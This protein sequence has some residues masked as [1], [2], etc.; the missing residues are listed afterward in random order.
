MITEVI[1]KEI[2]DAH[3]YGIS[4][5]GTHKLYT[6]VVREIDS[7]NSDSSHQTVSAIQIAAH[8]S[9]LEQCF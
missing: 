6:Q 8:L 3:Y 7:L 2:H 4:S 5:I 1:I 9:P